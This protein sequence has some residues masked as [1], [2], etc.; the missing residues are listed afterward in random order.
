[1][2]AAIPN[3]FDVKL[4]DDNIQSFMAD[5]DRARKAYTEQLDILNLGV[6]YKYDDIKN[7][8]QV[9]VDEGVTLELTNT[10]SGLQY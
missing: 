5:W 8:D 2:V 4:Y 9:E 10:S 6:S 3:W 1:M 7:M